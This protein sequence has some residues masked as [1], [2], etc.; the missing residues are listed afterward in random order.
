MPQPPEHR[1]RAERA[2]PRDVVLGEQIDLPLRAQG[3]A[4]PIGDRLVEG[5]GGRGIVRAVVAQLELEPVE[6]THGEGRRAVGGRAPVEPV[7]AVV[8]EA[9]GDATH[10]GLEPRQG[11]PRLEVGRIQGTVHVLDEPE[12]QVELVVARGAPPAHA[13]A[14]IEAVA[15]KRILHAI[16]PEQLARVLLLRPQLA[17]DAG[18]RGKERDGA[19]AEPGPRTAKLQPGQGARALD[20][21]RVRARAIPR[22]GPELETGDQRGAGGPEVQGC[23]ELLPSVDPRH[24]LVPVPVRKPIEVQPRLLQQAGVAIAPAVQPRGVRRG[25]V[26]QRHAEERAQLAG[27]VRVSDRGLLLELRPPRVA[28]Y[29]HVGLQVLVPTRLAPVQV[30]VALLVRQVLAL[31]EL[32]LDPRIALAGPDEVEPLLVVEGIA[33][34]GVEPGPKPV[35]LA[36]RDPDQ[37]SILAIVRDPPQPQ[38]QPRVLL[39]RLGPRL[40]ELQ[41]ESEQWTP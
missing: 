13:E 39:G 20:G 16:E 15:A 3:D 37:A 26:E 29:G 41:A 24:P 7:A 19:R 27:A 9:S 14:S 31:E 17:G 11:S 22:R 2:L 25:R 30:G 40:S 23:G 28:P 4:P 21:P 18:V 10:G 5:A 6:R 34:P 12:L 8:Q 35:A 33:T 38:V 36:G 1:L 32:G